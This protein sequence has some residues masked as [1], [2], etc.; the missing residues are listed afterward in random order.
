MNIIGLIGGIL[1]AFCGLPELIRTLKDGYCH[2]GWGFLS[3][4]ISGEILTLI[5]GFQIHQFPLI[6]N[7]GMNIIIISIMLFYKIKQSY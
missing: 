5:Y 6:L 1:L 3:I 2:V 4:W 7:C